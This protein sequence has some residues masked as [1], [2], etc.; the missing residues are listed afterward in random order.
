MAIDYH[1]FVA[2]L[3]LVAAAEA[4]RAARPLGEDTWQLLGRMLDVV[5]ATV[6][7]RLRAP[8]QGDGDDGRALVLEPPGTQRWAGLLALG[9]RCSAPR[10]GGHCA[11]ADATS[12]LRGSLAGRHH[13]QG[14]P[15]RR[16]CTSTTPA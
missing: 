5:A 13:R 12:T 2:E 8:R 11:E 9:E 3:G 1:G 6:D 14:C 7:V 15:T 16:P 4:D 10:T